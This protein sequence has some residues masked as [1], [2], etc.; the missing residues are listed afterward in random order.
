MSVRSAD[1]RRPAAGLR[2]FP[3][4][5]RIGVVANAVGGAIAFVYL[6]FL[7]PPQ[8]AP[9]EGE[10]LLFLGVAP[11]YFAA[12]AGLM[13]V[14]GRRRFRPVERWVAEERQPDERERRLVLALPWRAASGAAAAWAGAALLFGV[15]TATHHPVVF[16]AGV[17]V[18]IVL[19]G[20]ISTAVTF[21]LNERAMRPVFASAF[22]GEVPIG[23][24]QR[25]LRTRPRLLVSWALGSGIALLAIPLAFVGRADSTGQDLLPPVVFLVAAGLFAGAVSTSAAARA[26]SDPLERLRAAQQRVEAGSLGERVTVDDGGEIGLLQAGFNRMVDG[27][28]ERERIRAAFGTYLDR[29][30]ADHILSEGPSLAGEEVEVTVLFLD[31]RGFTGLAERLSAG[32][33]VATLNRLFDLAVPIVHA[34]GGHVDKYVGD[35]FLAVFGAPRP[36]PDHADQ[37]LAAALE[38]ATA[39]ERD[40]GAELHVG[41]GLNSGTV[42]A[43]NVGGGGRLEFS[44]IGDVVNVAARVESATRQTGDT[45]LITD[46]TRALLGTR[47]G[48]LRER[49]G[50]TLKGKSGEATLYA[51]SAAPAPRRNT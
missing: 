20:L 51:P 49:P 50:V 13:Y 34:H 28:R 36:Q 33:V 39:V 29:D 21:L 16:V 40:F 38:I 18:G 10:G 30:V 3:V 31:V 26:I 1:A 8:P 7:S 46:A 27:L 17:V 2:L 4:A 25:V 19:A 22:A 32:A 11:V 42:V 14:A 15:I 47:T 41:L 12:T 43:G 35:G 9:P 44:V 5:Y 37:A 48:D 24:P 23:G 45:V 6:S